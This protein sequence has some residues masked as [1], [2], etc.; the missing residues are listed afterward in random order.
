LSVSVVIPTRNEQNNI[1]SLL[2]ELMDYGYT[3][4][5][6]D[7]SDDATAEIARSFGVKVIN[8]Q[9]KGLG[10]AIVDGIKASKSDIVLVMDA[11]SSHRPVDIQRLLQPILENKCEMT[12]GSRYVKDGKSVGWELSRRIISRCAC[13]LAL[14]VT[15]VRD[16]TSG[17]FA[18]KKECILGL[19]ICPSSWKIMLEILVKSGM[20]AIEVPITFDVRKNGESKFN[21]KQAVAYLKHIGLLMKY[22]Y[23][24]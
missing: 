8:G 18:F 1:A 10:Q 12:I 6:V 20:K 15:T 24:V 23:G 4:I 22:K 21:K 5:V 11:D 3:I 16:S 14:P 2:F 7:D 9:R 13:L 19:K 17:F